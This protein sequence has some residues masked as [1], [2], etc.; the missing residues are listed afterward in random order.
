MDVRHAATANRRRF[1]AD[2]KGFF[3]DGA[4]YERMMGQWSRATGEIFIDWL[5]PPPG[6]SWLDVG[7]GT[8]AFSRLVLDR[9]APCKVAA[10]DP[11]PDQIAY[12][13][14]T[15]AAKQASFQ[16][17]DAQSLPF[18]DAEFDVAAM[19][20]VISFIPDPAKAVAEMRRVAK[21]GGT[22]GTYVWDFCSGGSTLQP[23]RGAIEAIGVPVPP[24]PGQENSSRERLDE[25]FRGAALDLVAT[26]AIEIDV[27]YPDFDTYWASQTALAN[28]IVQYL[29]K[30]TTADVDRVKAYLR[31][32]LPKDQF[33]RIAYKAR[34][35]AA[36]GRVPA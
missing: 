10:V 2:T 5:A 19:A 30:M 23:L 7:C 33:G 14:T 15:A 3:T 27:S 8:G 35:S 13:R 36:K 21:P 18:S 1:M 26:R 4:A 25:L 24:T 17:G 20:L 6:L 12:A 16:V 9:C 28:N 22:I 11:S 31:E 32:H 29:Q 34:A